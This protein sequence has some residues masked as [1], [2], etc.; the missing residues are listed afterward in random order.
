MPRAPQWRP[1]PELVWI[2]CKTV[3]ELPQLREFIVQF[4]M[5]GEEFTS[6]VPERFVDFQNKRIPGA[7]IA[8][9]DGGVLVDL[10]AE[11]LTSG[12][13]IKVLDSVKDSFLA[14]AN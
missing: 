8:D 4:D 2:S 5:M 7:I 14:P 1:E 11:T 3:R 12:V 9:V 13:R 10:P 6:F